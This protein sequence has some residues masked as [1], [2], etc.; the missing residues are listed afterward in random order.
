M[1]PRLDAALRYAQLGWPVFPCHNHTAGGCSCYRTD[2]PSPTKHPRTRNGLHAA[3]TDPTTIAA[4]WNH[5]PLANLAIRTGGA[6][7]IVVIDVDPRHGGDRS[8][9][10]LVE[11]HGPLPATRAV[12]TPSGGIHLYYQTPE[13]VPTTAGRLAPGIDTRADGGYVLAPPSRG[14]RGVRYETAN[15]RHPVTLPDWITDTLTTQRPTAAI[16]PATLTIA[17]DVAVPA[18]RWAEAALHRELDTV[19]RA[20]EGERN[21]TLNR[22]AFNL[23]QIAAAGHLQPDTIR[24]LLRRAAT[25]AGLH[26]KEIDPTITSGLTAGLQH[27]RGP[28]HRTRRRNSNERSLPP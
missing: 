28:N 22:S 27:P 4:W 16:E 17:A 7:G 6:A 14:A 9:D 13:P 10:Q 23:G 26:P 3:T 21:A 1:N 20:K 2:C 19:T 25:N 12:R 18:E 5:W 11:R 24:D 15:G 8:L